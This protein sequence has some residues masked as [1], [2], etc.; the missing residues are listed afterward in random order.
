[1]RK[2]RQDVYLTA[3]KRNMIQQYSSQ[4]KRFYVSCYACVCPTNWLCFKPVFYILFSTNKSQLHN[5][6]QRILKCGSFKLSF[7]KALKKNFHMKENVRDI[8]FFH[9]LLF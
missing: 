3:G 2:V 5:I 8:Q 9:F 4:A 7:L 1:M 6:S